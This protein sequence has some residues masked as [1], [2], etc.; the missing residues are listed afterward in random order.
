MTRYCKRLEGPWSSGPP[1]LRL[2]TGPD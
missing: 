1:W 2:Y